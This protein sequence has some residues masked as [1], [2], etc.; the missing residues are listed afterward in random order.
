MGRHK[1]KI[2]TDRTAYQQDYYLKR[3]A[4][5][6]ERKRLRYQEDE[7]YRQIIR[8][9]SQASKERHR[10]A[11]AEARARV[12]ALRDLGGHGI[13]Q[14]DGTLMELF[15][16]KDLKEAVGISLRMLQLWK[17][18]G[19]LPPSRHRTRAGIQRYTIEQVAGVVAAVVRYRE[20]Y[21]VE[22]RRSRVRHPKRL[23]ALIARQWAAIGE[24][25]EGSK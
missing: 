19:I 15:T 3:K 4:E 7:G 2:P 20:L 24:L 5:L 13:K 10:A 17:R 23:R 18:D 9:S 1:N 25:I 11:R 12:K 6:A 14:M 21:A 8:D 16:Q 22:G